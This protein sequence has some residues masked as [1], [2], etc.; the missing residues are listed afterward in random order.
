MK[1]VYLFEINDVIANQM[2]LPYSTGLIWSYCI[3]DKII[4]DNYSLDGWFYYRQDLDVIFDQI[5]QPHIVGFN[6]FVWNWEFNKK[7]AKKI[8]DKFPNSVIVFGGWQQPTA[9]RS[10]GFFNDHSYVDILVHGE[11]ELTFKDIL[12]EGLKDNPDWK[13]VP[14]CSIKNPDLSTFVTPPRPRIQSIDEMPSPYLNGLFDT[15]VEDCPYIIE[16][17]IETTRGCPYSCTFCEIGTKYLLKVKTQSVEKVKKEIDWIT[18]N[19]AEFVYNADSNFGLI[20]PDHLELT[21]YMVGNK[22]KYGYPVG[23]RCDWAKNKA[24]KVIELSAMFTE[25]GMDKGL[26]VAL[27]SMNPDTLKAVKRR[28][29]DDGKLAKFLEMYYE[30]ELPAYVE[31][32]L[33][34]PEETYESFID[35]VCRVMELDQ[36]NYIGIYPLTAFPNTPFG[37]PEYIKEYELDIIE[38]Y[39]AF[40]HYDISEQNTFEREHMVVGSRTMTRE[41]YKKAYYFRWQVMYGHYLGNTQFISRFLR[42]HLGVPYREFYE[43]ML[44]YSYD[45][46]DTFMGIE[47]RET[48]K[49]LEAIIKTESPW[50]RILNDVKKDFAWDFEEATAIRIMQ[51]K[52]KFYS[53]VWDFV[54]SNFKI[55]DDVLKEVFEFNKCAVLDPNISYPIKQEFNHNIYSVIRDKSKL[56]TRKSHFQF[57]ADNYD[58]DLYEWGKEKLWWGRRVAACKT[59]I[60]NLKQITFNIQEPESH[61]GTLRN[62]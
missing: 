22:K 36:H 34:L 38:T 2:K 40:M 23:H 58:G 30:R 11:G 62:Q 28:N 57:D 4:T 46:E 8:K 35:G 14:G 59:K 16:T 19:K 44:Q 18:A 61:R 20:Q 48:I 31:L 21:K 47:L 5:K 15:I 32:I 41:E 25:A 55:E 42:H 10:E 27:Q 49:A 50:G 56:A 24:D 54:K 53:E 29:V 9:D 6:C 33:G 17:T 3:E 7:M 39:T 37:D 43:K 45:N 51:N 60:K 26:T 12:L 52:D 1:N 13:S